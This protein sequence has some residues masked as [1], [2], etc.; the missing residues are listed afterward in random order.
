MVDVYK[1]LINEINPKGFFSGIIFFLPPQ[2]CVDWKPIPDL[3]K[4]MPN[5]FG[6]TW[7]CLVFDVIWL[8]GSSVV[9][10][11]GIEPGHVYRAVVTIFLVLSGVVLQ[12]RNK[13]NCCRNA[14]CFKS[15]S[16]KPYREWHLSFTKPKLSKAYLLRQM[17][18]SAGI[19]DTDHWVVIWR[20]TK[21]SIIHF[22][23][24]FKCRCCKWPLTYNYYWEKKVITCVLTTLFM[25]ELCSSATSGDIHKQPYCF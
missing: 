23:W 9:L 20:K 10:E 14:F 12:K 18:S 17:F 22:I 19:K 16:V 2:L 13:H 15:P 24:E 1:W 25:K 3:S 6:T 11:M 21:L 8:S 7:V 5:E 4:L